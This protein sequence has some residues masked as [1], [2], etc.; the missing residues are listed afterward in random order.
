MLIENRDR[1]LPEGNDLESP[2]SNGDVFADPH[3]ALSKYYKRSFNDEQLEEMHIRR[4][5]NLVRRMEANST[6]PTTLYYA[7]IDSVSFLLA[8]SPSFNPTNLVEIFST[9][10]ANNML[11]SNAF[12]NLAHRLYA[13]LLINAISNDQRDLVEI[14]ITAHNDT[15][16]KIPEFVRPPKSFI[17]HSAEKILTT[18]ALTMDRGIEL[19]NLD[20]WLINDSIK[21]TEQI[22]YAVWKGDTG[23][24]EQLTDS[25]ILAINDGSET[26]SLP[27]NESHYAIN[28]TCHTLVNNGL[29]SLSISLM[30]SYWP[31][32][33][34]APKI[35]ASQSL[36]L[37]GLYI[38]T[39]LQNGHAD[40]ANAEILGLTDASSSELFDDQRSQNW[41]KDILWQTEILSN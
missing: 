30:S 34:S 11:E 13:K 39:L 8:N 19:T 31:L 6:Q 2:L 38:T 18:Q 21:L 37:R 28:D 22:E 36:S 24:A 7:D 15:T 25:L 23:L 26:H 33:Q 5:I 9:R 20:T 29:H 12:S 4:I 41:I 17:N 32:L 16:K 40:L 27:E 35:S 14:L 3:S 1:F 10:F